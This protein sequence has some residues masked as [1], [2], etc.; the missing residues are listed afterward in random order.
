MRKIFLRRE[1]PAV[2]LGR[3]PVRHVVEERLR[4]RPDDGDDVGAR[5]GRRFGLEG[6]VVDVAR[7]DDDVLE[8]RLARLDA[9]LQRLALFARAVD[10]SERRLHVGRERRGGLGRGG[11]A[12]AAVEVRRV[13]EAFGRVLRVFGAGD[14]GAPDEIRHAVREQARRVAAVDGEVHERC[15]LGAEAFDPERAQHGALDADRGVAVDV[16][17]HVGRHR[18]R[19]RPAGCDLRFVHRN[20]RH[21]ASLTPRAE[22][23]GVRSSGAA[24]LSG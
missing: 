5:V 6:V 16:R 19:K 24:C 23:A 13:G 21:A 22:P 2:A 12:F 17:L 18:R 3:R 20:T 1:G 10:A 9:R 11:A 8:R 4:R 15:A 14:E 7:R